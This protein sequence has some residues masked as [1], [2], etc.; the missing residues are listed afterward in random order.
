R[1][2]AKL[3]IHASA[4]PDRFTEAADI[5]VFAVKPQD[6]RAAAAA[7]ASTVRGK[8]VVSV[9][10]GIRMQDLSRWLGGHRR[11]IRCMPN[12]PALIGAGDCGPAAQRGVT[13]GSTAA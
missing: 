6:M 3:K 4:L 9:A 11:M 12:T 7:L 2:S 10:A 5:L 1:I 13:A 8:L